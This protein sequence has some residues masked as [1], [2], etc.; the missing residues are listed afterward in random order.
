MITYPANLLRASGGRSSRPLPDGDVDE[1]RKIILRLFFII[2]G[3][4]LSVLSVRGKTSRATRIHFLGLCAIIVDVVNVYSIPIGS[5]YPLMVV[6]GTSG[7][8]RQDISLENFF[9][10]ACA[11][12]ACI[13]GPDN[14]DS[15]SR[16]KDLVDSSLGIILANMFTLSILL[17][18]RRFFLPRRGVILAATCSVIQL[19]CVKSIKFPITEE[20][21]MIRS[22][23]IC[24]SVLLCLLSRTI[25]AQALLGQFTPQYAS[26]TLGLALVVFGP[27][28]D[29]SGR[30]V[31]VGFLGL[32]SVAL[33]YR[34]KP[35]TKKSN[36]PIV[37]TVTPTKRIHLDIPD[38]PEAVPDAPVET[39]ARPPS[40]VV[41]VELADEEDELMSRLG[42]V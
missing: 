40:A 16:I 22:I 26:L 25:T 10:V 11:V 41:V 1:F 37:S 4:Y 33:L 30:S 38:L 15:S 14:D 32:G 27:W 20:D 5:M 3:A 28:A 12:G 2:L 34:M 36:K 42:E 18:L 17:I 39:T 31:V 7:I 19:W 6:L 8:I 13:M 21:M 29:V 35:A 23:T 24:S 9:C